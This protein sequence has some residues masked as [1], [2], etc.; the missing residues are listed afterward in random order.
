M[1]YNDNEFNNIIDDIILNSKFRELNNYKH[2]GISRYEHSLNV[3]YYTYKVTKFLKRDYV[4]VTRA[5]LLHDFYTN[6]VEEFSSL[7]KYRLHPVYALENAKK[8]YDLDEIQEDIIV[9]HM[10]PFSSKP[11]KY[12]ESVLVDLI[13]DY[14]SIVERVYATSKQATSFS[15]VFV[16]LLVNILKFK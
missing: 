16:Y 12:F 2:H 10:F 15:T 7:K 9:K 5:A 6:E 3:A 1:F 14:S 4:K 13:D 11:P 8:Y